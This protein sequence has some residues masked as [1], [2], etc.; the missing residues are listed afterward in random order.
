MLTILKRTMQCAVLLALLICLPAAR[1]AQA[2]TAPEQ[3]CPTDWNYQIVPSPFFE[4]DETLFLVDEREAIAWRST[5][6][7]I[8]WTRIV[9]QAYPYNS[10]IGSFVIAPIPL[11]TGLPLYSHYYYGTFGLRWTF[12]H[13]ADSG[14]TWEEWDFG[15]E[16]CS[17]LHATNQ[18]GVLFWPR[19]E[20]QIGPF[21]FEHGIFRS[22]DDGLTWQKSL[23]RDR[24]VQGSVL[25]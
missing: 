14:D 19:Y 9:S 13:S 4:S 5:D 25:S 15:C 3:G 22:D 8:N 6:N 2:Q 1:T 20:Y 17:G 24:S 21:V 12:A 16:N 7:A 10:G 18:Q 11:S 23:D